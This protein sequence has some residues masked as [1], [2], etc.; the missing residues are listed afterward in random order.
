MLT[1]AV[2]LEKKLSALPA[3]SPLAKNEIGYISDYFGYRIHPIYKRRLFHWGVDLTANIGA[4]VYAPG[5]G[6][7]EETGYDSNG[8]GRTLIIK[9]GYGFKTLYGHLLRFN[10]KKGDEVKRG[11]VIAFVGNS[12]LSSGP[13]LH[14][15][16][17]KNGK[18]INPLNYFSPNMDT[19][20]YFSIVSK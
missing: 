14:Y 13:H 16:I 1:D 17:I 3:I 6:V 2:N 18:K 5:D 4:K 19:Q 12:G 9:H 11:D 20:E 15:E 10:V 7:V 8:Y